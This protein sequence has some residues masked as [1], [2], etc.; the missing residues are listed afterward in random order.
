[1][2]IRALL[3]KLLPKTVKE[4]IILLLASEF[5]LTIK[6]LRNKIKQNFNQS[7]SYQ[8]V[9][10]ELVHL[11]EEDIIKQENKK[12]LLNIEWVR[13]VGLF[14]DL[15]ISNYTSERKHSINK[16][17]ELKKDGDSLSF[18][19]QSYAEIDN[20]FLQFVEY[21]N[22]FFDAKVKILYHYPHSWWPIL[23]PLQEKRALAKLKSDIYCICNSNSIIDQYCASFNRAIGIKAFYS[24]DA[25]LHWNVNLFG[26]LVFTYYSDPEISQEVHD[27]FTKHK[28]FPSLDLKKLCALIEKKGRFR[29]LVVKDS[30]FSQN[31]LNAELPIFN[32]NV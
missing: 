24:K 4:R 12:Y 19:F 5:P 13:Q 9:H 31:V 7:V 22:E 29:L 11:H 3:P 6:E 23:Y 16:I 18:D 8:S 1:M 27:Y 2:I 14:S 21:F 32:K 17:L 30:V 26:D 10:K 25:A 15:I 28:T 20:Y